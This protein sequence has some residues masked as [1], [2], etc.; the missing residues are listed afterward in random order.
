MLAKSGDWQRERKAQTSPWAPLEQSPKWQRGNMLVKSGN[1]KLATRRNKG[2][3]PN[4][5]L[6]TSGSCCVP[7]FSKGPAPETGQLQH[8]GPGFSF[9]G[10]IHNISLQLLTN[11]TRRSPIHEDTACTGVSSTIFYGSGG[12]AGTSSSSTSHFFVPF[13]E[14]KACVVAM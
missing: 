10:I 6:A 4:L 12:R 13:W 1:V 7:F 3:R 14:T 2:Q 9:L 8:V 5:S 11:P